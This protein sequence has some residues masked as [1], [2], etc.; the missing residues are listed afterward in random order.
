MSGPKVVR[1]VT[2]EERVATSTALL[3]RLEAA[4]QEWE[5]VA[6]RSGTLT[7]ADIEAMRAR[8]EGLKQAL[9]ADRFDAIEREAPRETQFVQREQE[10]RHT[11]AVN[12]EALKRRIRSRTRRIEA[13]MRAAPRT[14]IQTGITDEQRALAEKLKDGADEQSLESWL[15]EHPSAADAETAKIERQLAELSFLFDAGTVAALEAK[16]E[17]AEREISN[18]QRR[19]MLLD[20]L[21]LELAALVKQARDRSVVQSRLRALAEELRSIGTTSATERAA[22]VLSA[23]DSDVA[24]LAILE[25]ETLKAL[26]TERDA[27]AA[28]ARRSAVLKGLATLGYQVNEGLETAWVK[29]GRVVVKRPTQPGY[30]VE[31]GGKTENGRLQVRVVA[32]RGPQDV[33]DSSRDKDAERMW[34]ADFSQLQKHI[35]EAGGGLIIERALAVGETPLKA[36]EEVDT[37]VSSADRVAPRERS[38]R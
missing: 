34:C 17:A 19:A 13:E 3:A 30:G 29:S 33:A 27:F 26:A 23:I 4:L 8:S 37:N 24:A 7:S 18:S 25:T 35:T 32:L 6:R 31:L 22:N 5:R 12:K 1:V 14:T 21:T 38:L 20:S 16:L 9:A 15:T 2:R 10:R 11:E 36:V 28:E